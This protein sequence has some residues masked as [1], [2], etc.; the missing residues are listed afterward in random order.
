[1]DSYFIWAMSGRFCG[2]VI[3]EQVYDA[4]G[5]HVG[6]IDEGR[7]FSVKTGRVIGEFY[8]EERVGIKT[9]RAYPIKGARATR[10]S[11]SFAK[12]INRS[13]KSRSG[14]AD[15]NF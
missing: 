11:R 1:M 2:K 3:D 6:R 7:I 13:G 4:D 5:Q 15:P 12:R 8:D 10:S 9:N 14:W